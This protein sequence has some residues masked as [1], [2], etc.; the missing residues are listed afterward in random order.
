MN[1]DAV[2]NAMMTDPEAAMS[3]SELMAMEAELVAILLPI[4]A[5]VAVVSLVLGLLM[6]IALWKIF[7]KSGNAGWKVLIPVYNEYM[8]FKI[9]WKKKYFWVML[10]IAFISGLVSGFAPYLPEY[11]P[12]LMIVQGVLGLVA[13][14]IALK[15]EF[16][17]AKAFGKGTGFGIGLILL[18]W[19]FY[20]ILGFGKAKF[21]RRKRRKAIAPP[22]EA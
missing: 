4:L 15:L 10:L 6:I 13:L 9:S 18:P 19:I 17:L 14:V 2:M 16:K 3:A 21:R 22:A 11:A 12:V 8:I 20:P 5:G 1:L 7:K